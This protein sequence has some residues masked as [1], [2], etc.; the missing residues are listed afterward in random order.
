MPHIENWVEPLMA[1]PALCLGV[2]DGSRIARCFQVFQ[3]G[4]A[5]LLVVL[6]GSGDPRRL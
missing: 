5:L 6:E 1:D 3:Q 4:S 2:L